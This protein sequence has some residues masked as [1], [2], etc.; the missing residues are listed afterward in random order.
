MHAPQLLVHLEC[1]AE[2]ELNRI[3]ARKRDFEQNID[4]SFL[5]SLNQ[6]IE[7]KIEEIKNET[8]IVKISSEKI[9]FAT[10]RHGR[11]YIIETIRSSLSLI[12]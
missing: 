4:I 6:A 5:E 11:N 1:S 3:R 2:T 9:N 10:D 12:S 8:C 7:D